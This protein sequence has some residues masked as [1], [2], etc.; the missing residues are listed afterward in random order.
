VA[1]PA[2]L[3]ARNLH[4]SFPSGFALSVDELTLAQGGLYSF[5]GPNGTG[6]TVL[7]EALSLLSP[8]DQGTVE[9]LG[10]RIFPGRSGWHLARRRIAMVLEE[11]Y[12]FRGTVAENV[13]YGLRARGVRAR[14]RERRV[15]R[16]LAL[17]GLSA[18]AGTDSQRLSGGEVQRLAI[19]QA[20]VLETDVLLLDEPTAHVDAHYVGAIE[21]LLGELRR[22]GAATVLLA[23]H[24]LEQAYRLSD[25]IF[26]LVE[27]TVQKHAPENCFLGSVAEVDGQA[28]FES[29]SGLRF[30]VPPGR[31][32]GA[33]VVVDPASILISRES[34]RSSGRNR[35]VGTVQA[36]EGEGPTVQLHLSVDGAQLAARVTRE[37]V[38]ELTLAQGAQVYLT[39]R[40][41]GVRV[42]EHPASAVGHGRGEAQGA[43]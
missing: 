9:L 16:A 40:A 39:F 7:F 13:A 22:S 37:S 36:V 43:T 1:K 29:R 38:P 23:T 34:V 3:V 6:K 11:P 21:R 8:A 31:V 27:G 19:A 25:E 4:K 26:V 14:E 33:R 5:V 42:Y 30:Q 41:T 24:D 12:P 15:D 32:C 17:L 20:L 2:A 10:E 35:L 28:W 18:L